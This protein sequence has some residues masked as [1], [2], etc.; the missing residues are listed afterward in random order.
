MSEVTY[1]RTFQGAIN[2]A[3]TW[4]EQRFTETE[5]FFL[6][7]HCRSVLRFPA[8]YPELVE[9]WDGFFDIQAAIKERFQQMD[10]S[11]TTGQVL[12]LLL[13]LQINIRKGIDNF[14]PPSFAQSFLH[15]DKEA[16]WCWHLLNLGIKLKPEEPYCLLY[17][18]AM[19]LMS[20]PYVERELVIRG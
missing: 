15:E 20:R 18:L 3:K 2:H 13:E 9:I 16:L 10:W 1:D 7:A 17:P 8:Y 4:P 14:L 11:E 12:V 6:I 19:I 5:A